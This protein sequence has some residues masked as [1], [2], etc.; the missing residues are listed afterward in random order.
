VR[1]CLPDLADTV[2]AA[3]IGV[4]AAPAASSAGDSSNHPVFDTHIE[5]SVP[6]AC[7]LPRDAVK[8]LTRPAKQSGARGPQEAGAAQV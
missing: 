8:V 4:I 5:S 6:S 2:P 1:V 7:S 3:C